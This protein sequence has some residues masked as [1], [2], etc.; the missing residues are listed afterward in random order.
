LYLFGKT[1]KLY[2]SVEQEKF[3]QRKNL[4]KMII[5]NPLTWTVLF[6]CLPQAMKTGISQIRIPQKRLLLLSRVLLDKQFALLHFCLVISC[7]YRVS[8]FITP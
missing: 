2:S 4:P 5:S 8:R 3:Q 1:I 6:G 7:D